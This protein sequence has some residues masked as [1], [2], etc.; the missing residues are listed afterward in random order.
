M[1]IADLL[2]FGIGLSGPGCWVLGARYWLNL[3]SHLSFL[4]THHS[5]LFSSSSVLVA[6]CWLLVLFLSFY[7]SIIQTLLSA[8]LRSQ[9]IKP[10]FHS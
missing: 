3:I 10:A 1:Q 5:F 2:F 7:H 9:I 8:G 4:I 6:G